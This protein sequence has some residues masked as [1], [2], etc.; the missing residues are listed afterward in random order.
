MKGSDL[1]ELLAGWADSG[2]GTLAQQLAHALRRAVQSGLLADGTP[3]PSE[4][5]MAAVLS[6]SRS[7]V[8]TA[9]DELRAD[10][11]VE[12][13]R[14]SGTRVRNQ[15]SSTVVGTRVAQ[16]FS[17]VTG[18]D[19]AAGNPP[20]PS[21]LPPVRLDVAAL[22]AG[23][24]GPG[25][26]PLGLPAL[27]KA[28]ADG[29]CAQGKITDPGQ[30]HVTAGAH[31]AI[32]LAVRALAGRG[33]LIAVENLTYTGIFD[34]VDG[35]GAR[36]LPV[37]TDRQGIVP[38]DLDRI[39]AQ[40]SPSALYLQTGPHNPTG[41]LPSPGRLSEVAEVLDR[42]DATVLEDCAL[43]DLAFSGPLRPRL[44]TLCRRAVV[45]NIGSFSKVAWG[46]LRLGWMRAPDPFIERTM[47]LRLAGDLGPSVPAQLLTLQF[48]PEYDDVAG[49]RRSAL[50]ATVERAVQRLHADLPEWKLMKPEGGSVLWVQLPV[51]ESDAYC[52]LAGRHGVHIAPG[53]VSTPA[54]RPNS[55]VRICVDRPWP[56]VEEGIRRLH[57][58]WRELKAKP[59]SASVESSLRAGNP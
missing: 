56:T 29:Y 9:L 19:L 26:E 43:A 36:P 47:Y 23:G 10:G 4:R 50:Q 5:S 13:R 35:V 25:I 27:R 24:N 1:A 49:R 3:L 39:L 48:L 28:L 37:R 53:S 14:G 32:S 17:S 38:H 8:T 58:A 42:H 59:E 31:Q 6:V 54:R 22:L 11:T 34:I 41:A 16:H 51:L 52:Q 46:G 15:Y 18:V 30:I 44:V 33:D 40:H 57:L 45:V 55:F 20:D 2:H 12:S 7:T 21:H